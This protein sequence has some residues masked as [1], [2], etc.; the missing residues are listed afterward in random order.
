[1]SPRVPGSTRRETSSRR[2]SGARRCASTRC[3]FTRRADIHRGSAVPSPW[4]VDALPR[5]P[6]PV[7]Q[8][9]LA[10]AGP[11]CAPLTTLPPDG[12]HPTRAHPRTPG[13]LRT[14]VAIL[15][16]AA[17]SAWIIHSTWD[18][19]TPSRQNVG[20][21]TDFRDA[22]YYPT[23]A[24][25]GR[26][27]PVPTGRL[28]PG[29]PGRAGV[30]ALQPGAS[31]PAPAAR[32]AL[33]ARRPG[34]L[35]RA[36][37]RPDARARRR[38]APAG[39]LPGRVSRA[40]SGSARSWCSAGRASPTCA[41]ASRRWSWCSPATSRSRAPAP[42]ARPSASSSRARS[43]RSGCRSQ[44][45]SPAGGGIRAAL[46]GVGAAAAVSLARSRCRSPPPRVASVIWPTRCAATSTSRPV[47]GSRRLGTPL[48][49]DAGNTLARATGLRP[50]EWVAS[51]LGAALLRARRLG[52]VA[53]APDRTGIRP[54]RARGDPG[55][56]AGR[57]PVLPRR[58]RPPAPGVATPPA[59][60][61]PGARRARGRPGSASPWP[62]SCSSRC[63]TPSAGPRCATCSGA[64]RIFSA[65]LGPTAIG[66]SLLAAF[67]LSCFAA[68]RPSPTRAG[69]PVAS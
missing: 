6:C 21:L 8:G 2:A 31:G 16:F 17:A 18:D 64:G 62:R 44:S 14:A 12:R 32:R 51:A 30:P 45:C 41:T 60:A 53:P 68:L 52:R 27:Q 35:L 50:S 13:W 40:S 66:L 36:Q 7:W 10:V 34:R 20:F 65:L 22:V 58:L 46:V 37:P 28:L 19:I 69:T 38:R 49:L 56:P 59:R 4:R 3:V 1:M 25:D 33:A 23:V 15:L 42:G 5:H 11:G 24:L 55:V 26:R 67:L 29:V 47:R 48:R 43:R 63:S 9:G 61:A 54:D 39:R 57:H